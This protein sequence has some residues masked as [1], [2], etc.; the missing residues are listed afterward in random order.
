MEENSRGILSGYPSIDKITG[1]WKKG[2]LILVTGR[3]GTGMTSFA[4]N[5][6][7]NAANEQKVPV[8]FFSLAGDLNE[9]PVAS[10][11]IP[12]R[13]FIDD[14]PRRTISEIQDKGFSL[15]KDSKVRLII[16]D[17]LEL[18][19]GP[20]VLR[21]YHNA[22]ICHIVHKLKET[23][24][25]LNIPIIVISQRPRDSFFQSLYA[26]SNFGISNTIYSIADS[27]I[28]IHREL[29]VTSE[30]ALNPTL[31]FVAK[32]RSNQTSIVTIP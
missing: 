6:A 21:G 30:Y 25:E 7:L 23:A 17:Y 8:G 9:L 31:I 12:E 4:M 32:Q 28:I 15:V 18:I 22:E 14:T 19:E 26:S 2:E 24:R 10:A 3:P 16:V 13:L 27:V 29:Y 1:G 11:I 20:R 5:I